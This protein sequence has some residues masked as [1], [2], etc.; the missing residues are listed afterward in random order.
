MNKYLITYDLK[1]KSI[2]NYDLLYLAIKSIGPW[3]H[4]LD[5]TWIIKSNRSSREIWTL[6]A[7]HLLKNDH[8]LVVRIDTSDEWGWLPK[9]AWDWLN[10]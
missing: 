4:H 5:S 2:K 8:I 7:R 6:L 3:W 9:N 10:Q 1:N